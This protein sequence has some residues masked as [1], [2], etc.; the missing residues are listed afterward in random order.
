MVKLATFISIF[1][2]NNWIFLGIMDN[3]FF[4][5]KVSILRRL[6]SLALLVIPQFFPYETF[7]TT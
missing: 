5:P 7:F 6:K 3:L 2:S 4:Y 1:S